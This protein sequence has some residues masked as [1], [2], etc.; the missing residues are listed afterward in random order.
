MAEQ[1]NMCTLEDR[2]GHV[3]CASAVLCL[4]VDHGYYAC[5]PW[6]DV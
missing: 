3:V 4:H 2:T 1:T 6:E 5:V